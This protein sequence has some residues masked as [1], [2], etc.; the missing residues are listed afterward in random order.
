VVKSW[1]QNI[2]AFRVKH[3]IVFINMISLVFSAAIILS[4]MWISSSKNAQELSEALISE[5][6]GAINNRLGK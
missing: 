1:I 5:M 4:S 3:V 6:Q 2:R